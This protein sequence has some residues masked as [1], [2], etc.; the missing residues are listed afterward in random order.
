MSLTIAPIRLV[1]V[2]L[3]LGLA[4]FLSWIGVV[5][6]SE[7]DLTTKPLVGWRGKLQ[8]FVLKIVRSIFFC[9][10]IHRIEVIGKKVKL[11]PKVFNC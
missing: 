2:I 10:G 8:K 11:L 4:G 1:C 7:T 6:V 9:M 5:G 3:L